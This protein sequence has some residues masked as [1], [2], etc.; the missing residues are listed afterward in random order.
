MASAVGIHTSHV[1]MIERG[2]RHPSPAVMERLRKVLGLVEPLPPADGHVEPV[3][4]DAAAR[5][6]ALLTMRTEPR[7]AELARI[8]GM[9]V[10]K[11]R[12]QLRV[13]SH[14]MGSSGTGM[15]V[16]DDGVVARL[17]PTHGL[18]H[19][20]DQLVHA[21]PVPVL[22]KPQA[23]VLAVAVTRGAIT[24]KDADDARGVDS[25]SHVELLRD[26]GYLRV[27]TEGE[28]GMVY[29]PTTKV[30][31]QLFDVETMEEVR[32][33]LRREF[34]QW[35]RR[36]EHDPDSPAAKAL[37]L[38]SPQPSEANEEEESNGAISMPD[39]LGDH[40]PVLPS[41]GLHEGAGIGGDRPDH[42][43]EPQREDPSAEQGGGQGRLGS[44]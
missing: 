39:A 35:M 32:A 5:L 13:L 27:T 20:R 14:R 22:T 24:V 29:L 28:R 21:D 36:G 41:G 15:R 17:V 6:G 40:P 11:V 34:D 30:I 10:S 2:D 43:P 26:R 25:R 8:A 23:E 1:C 7:L 31:E 37:A 42:A 33:P 3:E 9:D 19:L 16:L 38:L 4:V 12:H 18:A 44:P